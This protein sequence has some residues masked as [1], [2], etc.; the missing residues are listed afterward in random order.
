MDELLAEAGKNW[1]NVEFL[2]D[3]TGD[4]DVCFGVRLRPYGR[5]APRNKMVL[6][7]GWTAQEALQEAVDKAKEGRW[8]TLDWASR[9]WPTKESNDGQGWYA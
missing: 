9:P 5:R 6:G 2:F 4:G 7:K 8:E 3:F 1:C